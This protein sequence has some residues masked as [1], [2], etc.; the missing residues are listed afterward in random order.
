MK[1]SIFLLGIVA[2]AAVIGFSMIACGSSSE[3][4]VTPDPFKDF[5]KGEPDTA[6]LT[7]VGLDNTMYDAIMAA[8]GS[9]SYQ[10]WM[11]GSLHL[12]W[13]G[14]NQAD[15]DRLW[16]ALR[17]HIPRNFMDFTSTSEN[18]ATAYEKVNIT[19]SDTSL[20]LMFYD[21]KP[22]GD[23]KYKYLASLLLTKKTVSVKN[24]FANIEN[25]PANTLWLVFDDSEKYF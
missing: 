16:L 11:E 21:D 12:I 10:G 9:D 1:K 6:V 18:L 17:E 23:H 24:D 15:F 25:I 20:S 3:I 8:V 2:L 14:K 22:A 5:K 13:T 7:S 4:S 19:A